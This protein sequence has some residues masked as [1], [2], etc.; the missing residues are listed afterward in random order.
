M[1][2]LHTR[3][4]TGGASV[5]LM[6]AVFS[7]GVCAG[8]VAVLPLVMPDQS[9]PQ[10]VATAATDG[11]AAVEAASP[12]DDN[13]TDPCAGQTWPYI[14]SAC[15]DTKA[16][17]DTRQV[18]VISTDRA[19]PSSLAT[20]TPRI[21]PK[22]P[23]QPADPPAA[24]PAAEPQQAV[25][26]QPPA[27]VQAAAM[28]KPEMSKPEMPKP[29]Q[30]AVASP[31]SAPEPS[32]PAAATAAVNQPT[33]HQ[34]AAPKAPAAVASP[35]RAPDPASTSKSQTTTQ[36]TA[37]TTTHTPH[38]TTTLPAAETSPQAADAQR[39]TKMITVSSKPKRAK[40]APAQPVTTA[41]VPEQARGRTRQVADPGNSL[42]GPTVVRT[43]DYADGRRVTVYQ[44]AGQS[45]RGTQALA[46]GDED[47]R[48]RRVIVPFED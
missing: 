36:T 2:S 46:Y 31:P 42:G 34:P 13:T 32:A 41:S 12:A 25:A 15:A 10:K 21:E 19:A 17:Q 6:M 18:R 23:P 26:P 16:Q 33:V 38:Q 40:P 20:R 47:Q 14:D 28:S 45:S 22:A 37:L 39:R 7:A 8:L 30:P 35:A 1:S 3:A 44:R 48:V 43:Y 11:R 27:A 24:E 29:E 4:S 9:P 5:K